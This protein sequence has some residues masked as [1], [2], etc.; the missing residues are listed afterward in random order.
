M[1]DAGLERPAK[2]KVTGT[3]V[4]GART[5]EPTADWGSRDSELLAIRGT[6]H[7]LVY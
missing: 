6:L 7:E 4:A 1:R 3:A 2:A 5:A